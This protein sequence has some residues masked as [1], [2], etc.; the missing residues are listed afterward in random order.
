[1]EILSFCQWL[2][3]TPFA[4]AMRNSSWLFDITETTHTLGIILVAGTILLVDLRLLGL[5]L[6]K[7]RV[8]EVVER[9]VP[10]TLSGFA[11]MVFTG[12]WLFASEARKLYH[13]PAFRI[14]LVLLALAG[15]NAL[16]F[17]LT[18]YRRSADWDELR[19]LPARARLAG[20]VSL[21]L[22]ICIIAAGRSIAYGPGYDQN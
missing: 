15:L 11:F 18:V 1:V 19:V 2:E 7:E 9:I 6:K 12:G 21:I 16:V 22:W 14:K 10:W 4:A 13:S 5:G 20:M 3:K 17:H 8:S